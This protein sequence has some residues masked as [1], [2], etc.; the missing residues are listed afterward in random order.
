MILLPLLEANM[1]VVKYINIAGKEIPFR[2]SA[3][4][5][6]AYRCRFGRDIFTD[7]SKLIGEQE[8]QNG[9]SSESLEIF[10]DIAYVMALQADKD[11][12]RTPEEWLDSIEGVFSFYTVFPQLLELWGLNIKQTVDT[13]KNLIKVN[14]S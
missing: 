13:K 8:G 3:A 7:L 2:A 11:I 10:E 1:S 5:P 14:E 9:I 6:R 12:P 4:T